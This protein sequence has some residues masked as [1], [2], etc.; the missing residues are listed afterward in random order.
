MMC[1]TVYTL[2]VDQ[3]SNIIIVIMRNGYV[4][5]GNYLNI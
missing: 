4:Y 5:K 1:V 2:N 3:L